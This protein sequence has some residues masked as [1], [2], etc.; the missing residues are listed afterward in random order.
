MNSGGHSLSI[1]DF[2]ELHQPLLGRPQLVEALL[3]AGVAVVG[4][5]V[6]GDLA[7]E[8]A[9]AVPELLDGRV[10]VLL[11]FLLLQHKRGEV[12][13]AGGDALVWLRVGGMRI[14]VPGLAPTPAL[15]LMISM[16][17]RRAASSRSSV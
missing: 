1:S 6:A 12:L 17:M 8:L 15:A 11:V 10:E 9:G 16:W 7:G 14:G 13:G 4:A 5:L 3:V 2:G